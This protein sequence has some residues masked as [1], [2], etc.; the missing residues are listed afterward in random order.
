MRDYVGGQY[1]FGSAGIY[2]QEDTVAW[3]GVQRAASSPW[4]RKEGMKFNYQQSRTSPVDGAPDPDWQGPGI[5]RLTGYGEHVQINFLRQWLRA[6][7]AE[8]T[9]TTSIT[10]GAQ[11]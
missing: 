1:C 3:E 5:H 4:M 10:E 6:M 11:A 8:T 9:A 2:E 7:R